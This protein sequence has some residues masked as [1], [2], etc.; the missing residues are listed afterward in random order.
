MD[1]DFSDEQR[2]LKEA[3]REVMEKEIIPIADEYDKNKLLH[4]RNLLKKLFDK[5]ALLAYI[6]AFLP[7]EEGGYSLDHLSYGILLEELYRAYASLGLVITVQNTFG[8]IYHFGTPEQKK[9]FIPSMH[10]GEKIICNASTEPDA[11][12]N[13]AEIKTLATLEGSHYIINGTKTWISNGT[14]ADIAMVVAQTKAGSG[15]S[16]LCHLIVEREVSPFESRELPKIGLRS[17]PTAELVFEDCR[18]PKENLLI[19]SG[20]GMKEILS[21]FEEWKVYMGI[22]AV[23]VAQ[24]AIDASVRYAKERHQFGKPIGSFQLIQ[25]MIIDMI[26]ETEASRLL[27][28]QALSMLDKGVR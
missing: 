9:R 13:T 12:S 23:G 14:I 6:G 11:G 1:F 15:A 25:E 5:L 26:A 24:A 27:V 7:E 3:A 10:K 8:G 16:G 18:I 21:H 19:P 20:Q 2:M 17:S 4:D 22:G 28:F